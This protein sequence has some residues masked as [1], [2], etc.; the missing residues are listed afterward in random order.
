MKKIL[1][2]IQATGNGHVSRA[3]QI[4]PE[5][6]KH[7]EVDVFLSGQ[8]C[9][10]PVPFPVKY[11]STGI[12]LFYNQKGGISVHDIV[13]KNQWSELYKKSTTLPVNEYDIVLNDFEPITALA[14]A[15]RK[16]KSLQVSHQASFI[17][18]KTP[19]PVYKNP[20]G[21]WILKNYSYSSENIG[22]HFDQYDHFIQNPVIKQNILN[23]L[24]IDLGHITVYISGFKKSFLKELF[25]YFDQIPFHCFV[26]QVQE[27]EIVD[28]I[29]FKPIRDESFAQSM[30]TCHGIITG[31]GF[32]TPAEALYLKKKLLSIPIRNHYEQECNAAAL[33]KAGILTGK[34]NSMDQSKAL[35]KEWLNYQQPDVKIIP[36][37]VDDL[38]KQIASFA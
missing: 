3:R 30:L 38:A 2:S 24:P 17:S 35:I 32:E 11:S 22:F 16:K 23:A 19:R 27:D 31:G 15:L 12:S 26:P 1:Y 8:N 36:N 7:G 21:E 9:T 37:Q 5:L 10:L 13:S 33:K 25:N 18:K 29:V 28:N 14:C 4:I 34:L 20:L 6:K